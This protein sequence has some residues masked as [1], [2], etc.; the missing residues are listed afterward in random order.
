VTSDQR[1]LSLQQLLTVPFVGL[2]MAMAVLIALLSYRTGAAAVDSVSDKLLQETVKRIGQAIERHVVGSGAVL[3]AAFPDGMRAPADLSAQADALRTRFWIATSLHRDPNNYVYYGNRAGQFLGLWRHSA[4]DGELRVKY[5]PT[6]PRARYRFWGIAGVLQPPQV[7]QRMFDPRQ[8]PWYKLGMS[9]ALQTW[10]AIYVDFNMQELVAT[11]ARRVMGSSGEVDGVV[12]T[13]VS[14][15]AL[16]EFVRKLKVSDNGFAFI[17]ERDGNIIAASNA[18]NLRKKA[19]GTADRVSVAT[20]GHP[21]LIATYEHVAPL[22]GG[23]S[24]QKP[25]AVRFDGPDGKTYEAGYARVMDTAGLDWSVIVAV[26]RDDFMSD[27]SANVVRTIL[28]GLLSA[29]AVLVMGLLVVRWVSRDVSRLAEAAQRIGDGD[30]DTPMLPQRTTELGALA[31]SFQKM[32][33]QLRTDRLTG[34]SNRDSVERRL[35]SRITNHRRR[36]DAPMI[37]LLFVDLDRFKSVND[38]FGHAAGDQVLLEMGRRLRSV[39]RDTDMVARWAGDEF[40]VLL[41]GVA[42]ASAPER[43][44]ADLEDCLRTPITVGQSETSIVVGGTVGLA[45]YPDQATD[46]QTLIRVADEDMYKRKPVGNSRY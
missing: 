18:P 16:D 23:A 32:Q 17:V 35:Q 43:V 42:D 12:A 30:F 19:D 4:E 45:I 26:P 20:S 3:E 14:L 10:T 37:G 39:V 2:V 6:Q 46:P 38:R 29:L 15:R 44:R 5:D 22:L 25:V 27:I 40:V 31:E 36:D 24:L 41:D 21:A 11:R 33:L 13:D 8:R 7:E 9:T 1:R 28:V 34:L